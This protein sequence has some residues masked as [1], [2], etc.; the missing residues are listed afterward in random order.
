MIRS[1]TQQVA[2]LTQQLHE[3]EDAARAREAAA[4]AAAER[5]DAAQGLI[6]S[7]RARAASAEAEAKPLRAQLAELADALDV[8]VRA[9]AAYSFVFSHCVE[10]AKPASLDSHCMSR[11]LIRPAPAVHGTETAL[12]AR[13]LCLE[14]S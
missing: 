11:T 8:K 7:L 12:A 3:A 10:H 14:T 13:P 2:D 4:A 9:E 6:D 1:L 5:A